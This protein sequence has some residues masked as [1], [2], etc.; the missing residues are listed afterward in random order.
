ME[1]VNVVEKDNDV[2]ENKVCRPDGDNIYEEY[3]Q[4]EYTCVERKLMLSPECG[5]ETQ[6]HKLFQTRCTMQ[7]SL[8]DLI[9][10][11]RSHENIISK[12]VVKRLQLETESHPAHMLLGGLKK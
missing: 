12:D 2:I 10:D 1:G 8:Y 4:E 3:E 9:I 5:Y 7:R 6:H 11:I